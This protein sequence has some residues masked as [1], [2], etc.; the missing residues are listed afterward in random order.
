[1][2]YHPDSENFA[3]E[4]LLRIS[5]LEG[6]CFSLRYLFLDTIRKSLQDS[7]EFGELLHNIRLHPNAYP[8]FTINRD[9]IFFLGKIWLP[10][11]NLLTTALLDEFHTTPLGGH[12]GVAKTLHRRQENFFG[13]VCKRM[14]VV[15][16]SLFV[17]R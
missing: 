4:A 10:L 16:N 1:M 9:L 13:M 2:Q 6:Q 3:A 8:S 14:C 11:D 5:R 12:M 17:N 15:L 7:T